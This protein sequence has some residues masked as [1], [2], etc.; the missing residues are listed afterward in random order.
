[1]NGI[2]IITN[3]GASG[4][5]AS[6]MSNGRLDIGQMRPWVGTDGKSYV[7]VCPNGANV[8]DPASYT[9]QLI[10]TNATLRQDEWKQLDD[11]LLNVARTRL[12]GVNDLISRG[13]TFNLGNAMGTTVFEYETMSDAFSAELTMDA[14]SRVQNDRP[15]FGVGYLPIPIIHVDYQINARVLASSRSRGQSLDTASAE[16]A[17]RKVAEKLE[18]M[19]FTNTTYAFGAGTI[20]SYVNHPRRNPVT[21]AVLWD[22]SAATGATVVNDVIA[23]KQ[24]S[25]DA[26][27]YGPWVLYVPVA[28][29]TILD[30]DY[31]RTT[32]TG[33]T[34]RQRLMEINGIVDIKVIDTLATKNVLL[35]QMTS[36]V[37]RLVQGMGLTN[38]EWDT[39][40]KMITKYKVMTI[41]V[42][43]IRADYNLKSGVTHLA[44][45]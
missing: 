32:A 21:M 8:K 41:Q 7:S 5:V 2:D 45:S 9:S 27:H 3:S 19:L 15:D 11:V 22:A 44:G 13:L 28:Y 18:N 1:M 33:S 37:V 12:S 35:V 30:K 4:E 16:L 26:L 34:I 6:M 23:M 17:A 20:Y 42:P 10:N 25:I 31:D 43:Q 14:I 24:K 40:G 36:D 29:E 39:E 38:V